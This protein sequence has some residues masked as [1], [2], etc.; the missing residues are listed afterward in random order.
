MT[1]SS[2]SSRGLEDVPHRAALSAKYPSTFAYATIKDRCPVILCKVIDHLHRERNNLGRELGEEAREGVKKV[3]EQL[4]RLRYEMQT[5]KP[6]TPLEDELPSAAVWNTILEQERAREGQVAW[7]ES[8]WMLVECYMYRRVAQA[9]A[10]SSP[11]L[12][13]FD[14]FRRQKEESFT[15]SRPSMVHLATWLL[16]TL[17][18]VL[19]TMVDPQDTWNTLLQVCLWGNKCD[20][21]ISAGSSRAAEGDPVTALHSLRPRILSMEGGAAWRRLHG[22]TVDLVMDNSGFELFTDLCLADF[23][24]TAGLAATVRLRV[25]AEPWFVSDVTP[26][27]FAWTLEQLAAAREPA[28]AEVGA[29]WS[30]HLSAGRFTLHADPFWTLPHTFDR[31]A[32]EDAELYAALGQASLVIFKGDLNYRKLVG[33]L[34]WEAAAPLR[35]AVRGFLPAPLLALRTA[36]AD[37][38]VGLAA[39]AAEDA[40]ALDAQW[41]VGGEWGVVQFVEP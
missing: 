23:L 35:A 24:L 14:V 9:L 36:K 21:S 8:P 28:L 37:V 13:S 15:S 5:S 30:A 3:V 11:S 25:K 27:D 19:A 41:M 32:E 16:T 26:P 12:H 7:F 17:R 20:L 39:G 34:N 40:A 4:S 38:V 31:M 22:G 33:D 18:E 2:S 6:L 29:R 10:L 1:K